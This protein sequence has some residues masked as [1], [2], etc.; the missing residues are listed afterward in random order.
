VADEQT[1]QDQ[2]SSG[3]NIGFVWFVLFR[4]WRLVMAAAVLGVLAAGAVYIFK[5]PVYR[6]TAALMVPYVLDV[7]APTPGNPERIRTSTSG[8]NLINA[9]MRVLRSFDLC[10]KVARSIGPERLAPGVP[11]SVRLTKAA[12]AILKNLNVEVAPKSIVIDVAFEHPDPTVVQPVLENLIAR[13]F[14]RHNEI[15]LGGGS[16]TNLLQRQEESRAKLEKLDAALNRLKSEA[17]VFGS[18]EETKK[19]YTTKINRLESELMEAKSEWVFQ[20]SLFTNDTKT[21]DIVPANVNRVP[22]DVVQEFKKVGYQLEFLRAE[23]SKAINTRFFTEEHPTVLRLRELIA[24]NTV[25]KNKLLALYPM[26]EAVTVPAVN[27]GVGATTVFT[28][29]DKRAAFAA[30]VEVLSAHLAVEKTN[31]FKLQQLEPHIAEAQRQ[32]DSE[33]SILKQI[34]LA[35]ERKRFNNTDGS[36]GN[37]NISPVQAPTPAAKVASKRLKTMGMVFAG[38]FGAGLAL[39]FFLEMFVDRTVKRPSEIE[40][41]F[42][43]PLLMTV[44]A[45]HDSPSASSRLE[46]GVSKALLP[47]GDSFVPAWSPLHFI[48]PYTEALSNRVAMYFEF[49]K[50]KPKLVGVTSCSDGAGVSS[51]AE[52]LASALSE[53]GDGRVLIVDMHRQQGTSQTFFQGKLVT[54]AAQL[55]NGEGSGNGT[56]ELIASAVGDGGNRTLPTGLKHLLPKLKASDYDYIIFDMPKI[57]MASMSL[58][59][60]ALLDLTVMVVESEKVPSDVMKKNCAMLTE[61]GAKVGVVMNKVHKYVPEWLHHEV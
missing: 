61:S 43:L 30:K 52:G 7:A 27:P 6:S 16:E 58:R 42:K 14:E 37:A 46:A 13:Y 57:S 29:M 41:N 9:E 50:R 34:T 33:E 28:E 55:S 54:E 15:H 32:R 4:R 11:S 5:L 38:L 17:G 47:A 31:A 10:E 21:N 26:L 59:L 36:S 3:F 56:S 45:M 12:E 51:I 24:T 40:P 1:V 49:V 48:H 18:I 23:E 60:S 25:W 53:A 2:P 19:G 20:Q 22:E 39:A 44:P 35:I 8:D